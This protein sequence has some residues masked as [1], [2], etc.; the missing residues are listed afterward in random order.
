MASKFQDRLLGRSERMDPVR[1]VAAGRPAWRDLS[2]HEAMMD[3]S[4][5][6]TGVIL[7]HGADLLDG[8]RSLGGSMSEALEAYNQSLSEDLAATNGRFLAAAGVDPFGGKEAIAQLDRSL[9]LPTMAAVGLVANYE[10]INLDDKAF[11]PIFEVARHHDVPVLIHPSTLPKEWIEALNLDNQFLRTG[12]GFFLDDALCILRMATNGTFDKFPEVRFMFCQ[13]GGL[14]PYFCG[15]W[16]YHQR[17]LRHLHDEWGEPLPAWVDRTLSDYL[18][19]LW[20][21]T[22]TQDRY[23]MELV[24]AEA[25]DQSLVLGGD[26]PYTPEADGIPYALSELDALGLSEETRRKIERGNAEA[27]FGERLTSIMSV[28]AGA[29]IGT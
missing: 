7:V 19:H 8:L 26:H 24:L 6:A 28:G 5:V 13:A 22:H 11:E 12:L 16:V 21:D 15:R 2:V 14:A 23:G 3:R 4:G 27:L 17:Q 29:A 20:L 1:S 25:G 18:S 10:G 9:K